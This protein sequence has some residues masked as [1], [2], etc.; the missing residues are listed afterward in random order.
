LARSTANVVNHHVGWWSLRR[1]LARHGECARSYAA[2]GSVARVGRALEERLCDSCKTSQRESSREEGGAGL[3]L[4]SAPSLFSPPSSPPPHH[5]PRRP[6]PSGESTR[7]R[8]LPHRGESRS[9]GL[10]G[11]KRKNANKQNIL[12]PFSRDIFPLPPPPP[13]VSWCSSCVWALW[14][15]AWVTG[16]SWA[17]SSAWCVR[18]LPFFLVP[19]ISASLTLSGGTSNRGELCP[20][21]PTK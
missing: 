6:S 4:L 21:L 12:N 8:A 15:W 18:E 3:S 7:P 11:G 10:V 5:H 20:P 19:L 14:R 9:E 13:F 17:C 16:R 1:K 2:Y